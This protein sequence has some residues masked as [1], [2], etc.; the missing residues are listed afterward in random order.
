[1]TYTANEGTPR[2]DYNEQ[3]QPSVDIDAIVRGINERAIR[4]D[5][6][7]MDIGEYVLEELFQG[8]LEAALSKDPYKSR[9][10]RQVADSPELNISRKRLSTSVRA[11]AFRR[12][13]VNDQVDCSGL[14]YSHWASLLKETDDEKR[15]DLALEAIQHGW[16]SRQISERI[17][18]AKREQD[19][20]GKTKWILR[21]ME[22]PL[23]LVKD[24]EVLGLLEDPAKLAEQLKSADRLQMAKAIDDIVEK[25]ASSSEILKRAKKNIARI[26]LG[27]V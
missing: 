2:N 14:T 4:I 17:K 6:A 16:S 22:R 27:D 11:A 18:V 3:T 7:T 1:M 25:L 13:L 23:D 21:T 8:S 19:S 20:N 26:E 15:Q 10:L 24:Q 9:S 12:D 5:D